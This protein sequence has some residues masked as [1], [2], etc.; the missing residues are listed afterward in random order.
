M[1]DF[2]IIVI[3]SGAGGMTAGLKLAR[4]GCTVLLLEA[5]PAFG[6]FL[7]PFQRNGYRFDTGLHY[8]GDLSAG[9]AFWCLL[10]DLGIR[11]SL[12]FR[13]LDPEGFDRYRFPHGEVA[14][15]KGVERFQARLHR[16]FDGHGRDIDRYF[17]TFGKIVKAVQNA[18]TVRDSWWRRIVYILRHTEMIRYH[19]RSYQQILNQATANQRL[20][21]ALAVMAGNLGTPPERA[22]AIMTVMVMHHFLNGAYYPRGGSGALRDALMDGLAGHHAV[23]KNRSRVVSITKKGRLFAVATAAGRAYSAR[24]VISNV[25]PTLTI[26]HL[27]S[28]SELVPRRVRE[29]AR[30]LRPSDGAFYAF[31]GTDL[32]LPNLGISDANLIHIDG[33]DLNV[34]FKCLTLPRIPEKIPYFFLSSP[35]VKDPDGRHAP[36]GRHT[37]QVITG[38]SYKLFARWA[39]LPSGQRGESYQALKTD[40][41]MRLVHA[42]ERYIPRLSRHLE[43]VTFATPLSNQYWVNAR[44]GGNFGPDQIPSQVGPGRFIDCASGIPGLFLAGAGTLGGGVMSCMASGFWA[45]TKALDYLHIR[46]RR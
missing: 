37:L 44:Q 32:D 46:S 1:P 6:G 11:R 23:L 3:G 42:V 10:D 16:L 13:E 36:Q 43:S 19:R 33:Y 9:S 17:N 40:I 12:A 8:L 22:S 38:T 5:M 20:Q 27:V 15:C 41:G 30:R 25:D 34:I 4:A 39:Q 31:I 7:N 14:V 24:A 2:D 45:A 35:S 26:G 21:A 28:P 29:K 18:A